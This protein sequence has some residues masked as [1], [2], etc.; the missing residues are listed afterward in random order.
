MGL[1]VGPLIGGALYEVDYRLPFVTVFL[2]SAAAAVV[3]W[4]VPPE[5]PHEPEPDTP[6]V[7]RDERHALERLIH[8]AWVANGLGWALVGVTRS[9]F[10]KQLDTLV[11]EGSLRVLW[12]AQAP[13][14]LTYGPA[15]LSGFL[16]FMLSFSSCA[17]YLVMGRTHWWHGRAGL[18]FG[19]QVAA[20]AALAILGT[21]HSYALMAVCFAIIGVNCG[22]CFFAA[23]FYC[24]ANP[25]LKHRRLAVN[26]GVVGMGGFLAPFAF[27]WLADHYGFGAAFRYAPGL[28]AVLLMLQVALLLLAPKER[29]A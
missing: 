18:L 4:P 15:Q 7:P 2:M 27:G 14:L 24:T 29:K 17:M 13:A 1:A 21:T 5:T 8:S 25:V 20:A 26:E 28:V 6:E 16:A 19:L 12:E 23:S 22:V 9:V 10:P 3:L 11:A